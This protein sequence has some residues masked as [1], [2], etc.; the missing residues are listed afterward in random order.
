MSNNTLNPISI[1]T[2]S[3]TLPILLTGCFDKLSNL[4][5]QNSSWVGTS[6]ED[7]LN[8]SYTYEEYYSEYYTES[9]FQQTSL[10]VAS[11]DCDIY[12]LPYF[13]DSSEG[14]QYYQFF[15]DID[16]DL[17]ILSELYIE[18][19]DG[20]DAQVEGQSEIFKVEKDGNTYEIKSFDDDYIPF[21]CE[22]DGNTLIC[23]EPNDDDRW[24][25]TFNFEKTSTPFDYDAI[26][27]R[28]L[29]EHLED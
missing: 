21:V 27:S 29:S 10:Q 22:K 13:E 1:A 19:E 14:Y 25:M 5:P 15:L 28:I 7:C 4:N 2:P 11:G 26:L 23:T 17:A 3:I 18:I 12:D 24:I 9:Y 16:G 8:E 6:F 20:A